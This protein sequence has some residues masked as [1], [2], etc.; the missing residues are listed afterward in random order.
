MPTMDDRIDN[1]LDSGRFRWPALASLMSLM[2]LAFLCSVG[3]IFAALT[4]TLF[5]GHA[6]T[7]GQKLQT[8]LRMG[9]GLRLPVCGNVAP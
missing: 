1:W 9:G 5:D 8:C 2:M 4:T 3:V 7:G 6:F